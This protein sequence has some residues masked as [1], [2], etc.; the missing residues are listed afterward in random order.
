MPE[1]KVSPHSLWR[2]RPC[3]APGHQDFTTP[4]HCQLS[5]GPWPCPAQPVLHCP[6]A[7]PVSLQ[8]AHSHL[9]A[10]RLCPSFPFLF[11]LKS[12]DGTCDNGSDLCEGRFILDRTKCFFIEKVVKHWKM[13][14]GEVVDAQSLSV[15]KRRLDSALIDCFN[16][17][18]AQKG[19]GCWTRPSFWSELQIIPNG[20]I[21]VQSIPF[22]SCTCAWI[23]AAAV[24]RHSSAQHLPLDSSLIS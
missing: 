22:H 6:T 10:P 16:F 23:P 19:S 20:T 24:L 2:H 21:L 9:T 8:A 12:S 13:L 1:D 18:P 11:S 5:Q 4:R 15:F 3:C 7:A 14:P 17:W